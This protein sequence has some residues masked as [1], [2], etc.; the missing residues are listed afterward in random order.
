MADCKVPKILYIS[1]FAFGTMAEKVFRPR[2]S[3]WIMGMYWIILLFM[4]AMTLMIPVIASLDLFAAVVFLVVLSFAA[5][6]FVLFIFRAYRMKYVVKDGEL[7]IH[8]IFRTSTV[9]TSE[10]KSAEKTLIPMGFKLFGTSFLGG[11]YYIPGKGKVWVAMG[12]FEDGV[13][14][15]TKQDKHYLI[16]PMG[17]EKFIKA[18][19]A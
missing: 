2:L 10:I 6:V 19:K 11:L 4:L 7:T 13:M 3:K 15:S 16:T 9:K 8:G 1:L 14:I 18:L 17:P 5:L 12:N